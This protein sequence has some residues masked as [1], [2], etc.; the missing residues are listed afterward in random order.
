MKSIRACIQSLPVLANFWRPWRLTRRHKTALRA[1]ALLLV[2]IVTLGGCG[3]DNPVEPD[4]DGLRIIFESRRDVPS[5][6]DN[7]Q[8]YVELYTMAPDGTDLRRITSNRYW[9]H[10]P[11][12]S[13]DG[14]RILITIHQSPEHVDETDPGWEIAVMNW[15]GTELTLLTDNDFLDTNARWNSDG[16]RVVFV[17]D[18]NERTSEDLE[19]GLIQQLDIYVMNADGTG[20]TR[21]TF[22]ETGDVNADPCFSP[23]GYIYYIHSEGFSGNFDLWRM[24]ADGTEKTCFLA[25]NDSLRAINDPC[26][27]SD[28]QTI[29][30]EA[31]VSADG[32]E[33]RRYNLFTIDC[34]GQNLTRITRDDGEADIW[35]SFSPDG[36]HIVYFT[37][38]WDGTGGHTERIRVAK[39]DG[40]QER[41]ISSFPWEAFP[42]WYVE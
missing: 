26:V 41:V 34:N 12:V 13:P 37:Y 23:D 15:D 32:E 18:S 8:I 35:P 1:C 38:K 3:S 24:K 5:G 7:P 22:G 36:N 40:S 27:S 33:P 11:Q 30:F 19:D 21:L 28:G 2:I 14:T 16:T 17:S 42:S 20:R 4:W 29:I 39:P 9:E 10:K 25:H 31:R 6:A